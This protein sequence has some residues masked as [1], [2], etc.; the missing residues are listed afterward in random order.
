M[1]ESLLALARMN[2]PWMTA[3]VK[4]PRF[5]HST[6]ARRAHS[7]LLPMRCLARH[8]TRAGGSPYRTAGLANEGPKDPSARLYTWPRQRRRDREPRSQVPRSRDRIGRVTESHHCSP[9]GFR[10]K[11]AR[12]V[13]ASASA[14]CARQICKSAALFAVRN[15][16]S[17]L[18]ILGT[19]HQ[20][21][22]T[23]TNRPEARCTRA[24][25]HYSWRPLHQ[26]ES[27]TVLA[28]YGISVDLLRRRTSP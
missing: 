8:R 26:Q 7:A 17:R 19:S 23:R 16:D 6:A 4:S 1:L 5:S 10:S 13:N 21:C 14:G 3:C 2:A 27:A 9:K 20:R 24:C 28:P 12:C 15:V 25:P 22:G 11:C 18:S